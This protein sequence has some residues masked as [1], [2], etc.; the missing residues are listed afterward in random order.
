MPDY[1]FDTLN[2][3]EFELLVRDLLQ[4]EHGVT[5]ESFK[6]GQDGG[7]DLRCLQGNGGTVIVQCK[8][9]IE[10]DLSSLKSKCRANELDKVKSLKPDRYIFV[11]SKKLSPSDKK[12][13][14]KIFE[15]FIKS[16]KD[17]IG[18]E[19]LNNFLGR[20]PEVEE[21]H[22]KL[23]LSSTNILKKIQ[24]QYIN[25]RSTLFADELTEKSKLF[26]KT[27]SFDAGLEILNNHSVLLITGEPGIGKTML[28]NYLVFN[29]L[30]DDFELIYIRKDLEDIEKKFNPNSKQIFYFDDFLGRNY[31]EILSEKNFD[32]HLYRLIKAIKNS[33][34][35]YFILTS[36]T[37]IY[38]V[39]Q[40]RS[41]YITKK[42]L[43]ALEYTL[44]VKNYSNIDRA[45]IL[46]NHMFFGSINDKLKE[47]IKADEFYFEII[48]HKNF[49]PRMIEFITDEEQIRI[50]SPDD[51]NEFILEALN[52]P[53]EIWRNA[54]TNQISN[55]DKLYLLTLFS[56]KLPVDEN[57]FK[58]ALIKRLNYDKETRGIEIPINFYNN[59][60]R[61]LLNGFIKRS[62]NH[63]NRGEASTT[64]DFINPSIE[65]FF[66]K[67]LK[68]NFELVYPII[69]SSVFFE[70]ISHRFLNY[71]SV[72][73]KKIDINKIDS[74]I[75][76]F[77]EEGTTRDKLDYLDQLTFHFGY[78][79]LKN[80]ITR[81][82]HEILNSYSFARSHLDF[83][84]EIVDK[85]ACTKIFENNLEN[86]LD[87]IN[88]CIAD[89]HDIDKVAETLEPLSVDADEFIHE[90]TSFILDGLYDYIHDY[91]N[92]ID[93]SKLNIDFYYGGHG[94]DEYFDYYEHNLNEILEDIRNDLEF[95]LV[96]Y[97]L[98]E[99][100]VWM[101]ID[102]DEWINPD[103]FVENYLRMEAEGQSSYYR[104]TGGNVG[105]ISSQDKSTI[106]DIF[107]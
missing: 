30:K 17:V 94:P 60:L 64:I 78:E 104:S 18:R 91:Y 68:S 33:L 96:S 22:F 10:T 14:V 72:L 67:Y 26:V 98:D 50:N 83:F 15:P 19:D 97:G 38:N 87:N 20:H 35:H 42:N 105:N 55:I 73:S 9:Y 49:N 102:F 12:D 54:F 39:A 5:Y 52:D 25:Y 24:D 66:I 36:R 47:L 45:K 8:H 2:F 37:T 57:A 101:Y 76:Y 48:E 88:Q 84:L 71:S 6:E 40:N 89:P 75:D 58:D 106:R 86:F 93:T 103:D 29:F 74:K 13:F 34:N 63:N 77:L 69:N 46:Y 56:F 23:W 27:E 4:K 51:Y 41:E 70:Q 80:K 28:A 85:P 90:N 44:E 100:E 62:I 43:Q 21:D 79:K 65:D 99:E 7:I 1:S 95:E 16:D 107:K 11:T 59:S 61:N 82:L 92:D 31:L 53:T 3:N 32:S 81:Y